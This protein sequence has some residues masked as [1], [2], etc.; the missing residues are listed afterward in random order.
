MVF[1]IRVAVS[2]TLLTSWEMV[3][4]PQVG[5]SRLRV[6]QGPLLVTSTF[7]C[8]SWGHPQLPYP[9]LPSSPSH[10]PPL[11]PPLSVSAPRLPPSV[12]PPEPEAGESGDS[13]VRRGLLEGAK[14]GGAPGYSAGVGAAEGGRVGASREGSGWGRGGLRGGRRLGGGSG[15][16][17]PEARLMTPARVCLCVSVVPLLYTSIW[18][19]VSVC[20]PV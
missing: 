16:L 17:C 7:G 15:R 9:P 6:G 5:Q 18:S 12:E 3:P 14:P 10:F 8:E 19:P 2:Y 11:S 20:A 13:G 4:L 1:T